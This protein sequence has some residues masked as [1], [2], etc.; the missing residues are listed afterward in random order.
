MHL[1]VYRG[2][3]FSIDGTIRNQDGDAVNLAGGAMRFS[4][5]RS[6]TDV[7]YII[8]KPCGITDAPN[9]KF[10]VSLLPTETAIAV[11]DYVYDIQLQLG[12]GAVHTVRKGTFTILR[13]IT[14]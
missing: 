2:D 9:G 5:K 14:I 11:S 4:V 6:P 7:A 12:S 3:S 13:D 1:Q 8:S 10:N